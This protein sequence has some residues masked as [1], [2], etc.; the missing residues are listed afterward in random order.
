MSIGLINAGVYVINQE[1]WAQIDVP[2]KFSFEK[3]VLEKYV[4]VLTFKAFR[5]EGYFIDIGVPEDYAQ[6][7]LDLKGL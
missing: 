4:N 6:A 7:N 1:L 2:E 5:H 3:D